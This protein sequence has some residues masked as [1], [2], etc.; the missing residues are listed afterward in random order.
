[1]A[2]GRA[3]GLLGESRGRAPELLGGPGGP[4]SKATL[5][6]CHS[7]ARTGRSVEKKG[8]DEYISQG[9]GH[10]PVPAPVLLQQSR[11]GTCLETNAVSCMTSPAAAVHVSSSFGTHSSHG[12]I[13][14]FPL[15]PLSSRLLV[16]PVVKPR[17]QFI[18]SSD[19]TC[20]QDGP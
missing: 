2:A 19:P 14:H 11:L 10:R 1:M 7:W 13:P 6:C 18:Q 12:F 8:G 9:K 4:S 15:Q 20:L 5:L 16:M 17:G 3:W